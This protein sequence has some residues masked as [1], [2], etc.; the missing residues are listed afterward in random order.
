VFKGNGLSSRLSAAQSNV[1]SDIPPSSVNRSVVVLLKKS[2]RPMAPWPT[3]DVVLLVVPGPVVGAV[4][5]TEKVAN[6]VLVWTA[7]R[8]WSR[9]FSLQLDRLVS[10]RTPGNGGVEGMDTH[11]HKRAGV[12]ALEDEEKWGVYATLRVAHVLRV[13]SKTDTTFTTNKTNSNESQCCK[14]AA[15]KVTRG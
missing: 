12:E 1:P 9:E 11:C 15:E 5:E 3:F 6:A 7:L 13:V 4:K 14:Y 10:M 2:F 8:R